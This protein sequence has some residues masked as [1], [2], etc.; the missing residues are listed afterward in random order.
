MPR[1]YYC[2]ECGVELSIV[3][4][5]LRNKGLIVDLVRP[6]E[7]DESQLKNITDADKPVPKSSFVEY[8][9]G[10]PPDEDIRSFVPYEPGDRRQKTGVSTAPAVL[11]SL[12]KGGSQADKNSTGDKSDE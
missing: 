7:C 2:S 11:H 8:S 4:K 1:H 3:R 5:S 9:S 12:I 10:P 6:H